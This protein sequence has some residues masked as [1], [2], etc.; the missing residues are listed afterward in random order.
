MSITIRKINHRP[1]PVTV[2]IPVC[3]E[4]TG[5]V[6]ELE[7]TFIAH[8]KAFSESTLKAI[9]EEADR[10]F[11]PPAGGGTPPLDV[12]LEKNAHVFAQLLTGWSAVRD[13]AGNDIP[14]TEEA[15]A[16]WVCGPDGLALSAGLNASLSEIRFGV[17]PAKNSPT[18]PA[19]GPAPAADEVAAPAAETLAS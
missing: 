12:A 6:N 19:P 7:Q 5:Q 11:P 9:F 14:Y 8:W 3:D 4:A 18:S 15:L 10:R 13:E 1:W 17:A 16:G 2:R